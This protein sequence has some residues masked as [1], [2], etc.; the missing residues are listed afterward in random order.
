[1]ERA[2]W[3]NERLD[4]LATSMREGFARVD[5][6]IRDLRGE[7]GT[8]RGEMNEGFK[9]LRGEISEVRSD[10]ADLRAELR[11][12]MYRIGGG[13]MIGLLGVIAAILARGV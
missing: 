2:A 1:M 7:I 13:I 3:T 12:V 4:D 11:G 6:D 8:L 9:Q 10:V 5:T